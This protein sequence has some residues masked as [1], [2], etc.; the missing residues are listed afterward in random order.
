M[1]VPVLLER[2][3]KELSDGLLEPDP[4]PDVR[5][6]RFAFLMMEGQL[7]PV[8]RPHYG[9]ERQNVPLYSAMNL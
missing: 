7:S 6:Q 8:R 9:A 5:K 3:S 4:E 1:P 2:F